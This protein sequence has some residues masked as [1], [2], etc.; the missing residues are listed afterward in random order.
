M[1]NALPQKDVSVDLLLHVVRR[2]EFA[3]KHL[4]VAELSLALSNDNTVAVSL[5]YLFHAFDPVRCW[6]SVRSDTV[7]YL[8]C[9]S[10]A[11][12]VATASKLMSSKAPTITTL[13][14]KVSIAIVWP[15][16]KRMSAPSISAA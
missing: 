9:S 5:E 14:P 7:L 2:I 3:A 12:F 13:S 8:P 15:M 1:E 4:R 6:L 11:H 10:F 16:L